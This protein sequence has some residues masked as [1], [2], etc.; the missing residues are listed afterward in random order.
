MI[1]TGLNAN[2]FDRNNW[3]AGGKQG[4]FEVDNFTSPAYVA[5]LDYRGVPG[6]RIGGSFYYCVN[7][8]SN[9][10][11]VATYAGVKAPLRIYTVDGQYKN[12]YVTAVRTLCLAT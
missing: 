7:T 12:K 3:V 8:A 11:K 9:S 10:D 4:F 1:V 5:R 6:L 2:G